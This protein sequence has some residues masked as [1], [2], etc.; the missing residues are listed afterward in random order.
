VVQD[1]T[2]VYDYPHS[3]AVAMANLT[4]T[5]DMLG[6]SPTDINACSPSMSLF[7]IVACIAKI[8]FSYIC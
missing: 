5:C 7:G 2:R 6:V 4:V 8:Y 1:L 3:G